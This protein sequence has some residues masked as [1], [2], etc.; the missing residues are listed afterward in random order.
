M[1]EENKSNSKKLN[2]VV[3]VLQ[4]ILSLMFLMGG[5]MKLAMPIEEL[6]ANMAWIN[7]VPAGLVRF[8]GLSEILGALGLVFPSL[9][10]IQPKLTVYAA[11]GLALIMIPAANLHFSLHEYSEIIINVVVGS[12]VALIAWARHKRVVIE[13]R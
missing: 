5:F 9:L 11:I 8:I 13:P 2:I 12:I 10:R 3:W 4:V 6:A 7:E 1:M